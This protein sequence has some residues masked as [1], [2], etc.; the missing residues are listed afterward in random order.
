M[1]MPGVGKGTQA[2]MLQTRTG[3]PHISTGE[4]LRQAVKD[5]T[6]LGR[7]V[8]GVL[9]AGQ[10][11]PDEVMGKLIEERL[12]RADARNGFILDGFPRTEQQVVIL[13]GVL[14]KL[15]VGL[16]GV[17]LLAADEDE[18][19]GRLSNRRICPG[20]GSV[21]HLESNPPASPG[22]CDDCSS[23]LVQRPDD[24]ESVIRDRLGVYAEQTRPAT[25]CY[26]RKNLLQQ[27]D[28]G[29]NPDEIA[30]KLAEAMSA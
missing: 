26:R 29:G 18:I 24:T 2:A 10:L 22:V 16:D 27:I 12:G 8:E 13:D 9:N 20:C 23:A 6:P 14:E 19:I 21:F 3:V 17:Y 30:K 1:G 28:A 11:V 7:R 5:R 15:G 25:E 4:I